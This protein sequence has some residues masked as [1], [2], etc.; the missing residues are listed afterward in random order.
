MTDLSQTE[1]TAMNE[2]RAQERNLPSRPVDTIY[3]AGWIRGRDY[4]RE[5]ERALREAIEDAAG[6]A[7]LCDSAEKLEALTNRLL[8]IAASPGESEGQPGTACDHCGKQAF[9]PI[10][11]EDGFVL[12]PKCACGLALAAGRSES[13]PDHGPGEPTE[14]EQRQAAIDKVVK[15]MRDS[16]YIGGLSERDAWRTVMAT[17]SPFATEPKAMQVGESNG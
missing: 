2:A 13:Q 12:C 4:G 9:E 1:H 15:V 10:H 8:A 3:E 17:L 16:E 6:E 14:L 7:S 5:R 11:G